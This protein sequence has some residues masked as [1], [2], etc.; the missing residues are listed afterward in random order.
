MWLNNIWF[1]GFVANTMQCLNG[2]I[3]EQLSCI[4][5]IV[6][7][8]KQTYIRIDRHRKLE[9][10]YMQNKVFLNL[11][12]LWC[13][14]MS[15]IYRP[16]YTMQKWKKPHCF[17]YKQSHTFWYHMFSKLKPVSWMMYRTNKLFR[18]KNQKWRNVIFWFQT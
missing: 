8:K 12:T 1:F 16:H 5:W 17:W 3:L 15:S 11:I 4:Y 10:K 7:N 14:S 18:K 2:D 9:L 6:F 13:R